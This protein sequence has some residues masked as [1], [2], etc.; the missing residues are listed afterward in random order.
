MNEGEDHRFFR[1][2][3]WLADLEPERRVDFARARLVLV[4]S[5]TRFNTGESESIIVLPIT[6]RNM[7]IPSHVPLPWPEGGVPADSVILCDRITTLKKD[8]L[9]RKLGSIDRHTLSIVDDKLAMLLS[10]F[11]PV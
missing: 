8:R 2:E 3:I 1:G 4:V 6:T 5:D 9:M 7:K 10:L 11:A